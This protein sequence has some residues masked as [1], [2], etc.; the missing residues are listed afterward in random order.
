MK[1]LLN[2]TKNAAKQL[3]RIANE[4]KSNNILFYIKGGGCNGFNY[5]FEPT[6]EL[7]NKLDEIVEL[8]NNKNKDKVNIIICNKSLIHLLGTEIDWKKTVM[9]E[10][11]EFN[12]P[13]A[14]S[15]CGCGSSFTTKVT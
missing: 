1:K 8:P 6:N 12:N 15:S 4:T 2:I 7:P 10:S 3:N 14:A 9:G 5:K 11:F 13:N